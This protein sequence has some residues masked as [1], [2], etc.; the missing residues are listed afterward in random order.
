MAIMRDVQEIHEGTRDWYAIITVQEKLQPRQSTNGNFRYQ[1]FMFSD[2]KLMGERLEMFKT[3]RITNAEVRTIPVK[4]QKPGITKTWIINERTP[5][6]EVAEPTNTVMV[7][8]N[9]TTFDELAKFIDKKNAPIDVLGV[10]IEAFPLRSI[11]KDNKEQTVQKYLLLSETMKVISLSLWNEF[12]DAVGTKIEHEVINHPVVICQ[13]VNVSYFNGIALA[14]KYDSMILVNPPID[15]ALQLS[16]W[17]KVAQPQLFGSKSSSAS[18]TFPKG[19]GTRLAGNATLQQICHSVK[20]TLAMVV[21]SPKKLRPCTLHRAEINFEIYGIQ[22]NYKILNRCRFDIDLNDRSGTITGSAYAELA[23]EILELPVDVLRNYSFK[24]INTH[25]SKVH[26][27]F[28]E[29]PFIVQLKPSRK[30]RSGQK[31][32][33][34]EETS[35]TPPHENKSMESSQDEEAEEEEPSSENQKPMSD[36]EDTETTQHQ[37][38]EDTTDEDASEEKQTKKPKQA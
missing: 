2:S 9:Y 22:L 23:E 31:H 37:E 12:V 4:F 5:V 6:M 24:E 19:I 8:Y 7:D 11:S 16:T 20:N 14:N 1:K 29:K 21:E 25:L 30:K 13:R 28:D 3:Y 36:Y 34:D 17:H 33:S 38:A 18:K 35:T 10:V 27:K 32:P 26:K 15:E